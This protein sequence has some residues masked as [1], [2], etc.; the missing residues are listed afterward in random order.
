M[1]R[2]PRVP[3]KAILGIIGILI[4]VIMAFNMVTYV[5]AGERVV[6]QTIGGD[7]SV[8]E[9]PGYKWQGLA[10]VTSY[11]KATQ[12]DFDMTTERQDDAKEYEDTSRCL[13]IRFND[14]GRARI[15]GTLRVEVPGGKQLIK[16]HEQF[17]SMDSIMTGL[18]APA[19]AKATYQTG[20]LMSSRESAAEKRGDLQDYIV[21]QARKGFYKK[22][23]R[24][25]KID[26]PS[27]PMVRDKETGDMRVA[28]KLVKISEPIV[29]KDGTPVIQEI[30]ALAEFGISFYNFAIKRIAYSKSVQD[31]IEKQRE[32]EVAIQTAIAQAKKAEQD[33]KTAKANEEAKVAE[34]RAEMQVEKIEAVTKAEKERD[35]A[36]LNLEKERL[37]AEAIIAKGKAE[38][39]ARRL[40]MVADGAL[41]QKLEALVKIN[42]NYAVALSKAQ[43]GALVPTLIM[44]DTGGGKGGANDLVQ[45]LTAQTARQLSVDVKP[46]K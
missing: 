41:N 28:K 18:V 40:K 24:E 34:K 19:I 11:P 10:K 4:V 8:F 35:V 45:L 3:W 21:E 33:A 27:V 9:T 6:K 15:C 32:R 37:N 30:S 43:P 26:D 5:D 13:P 29:G 1:A 22:E 25:V 44:G 42:E 23:T 36:E 16:L 7:L 38:A 39:E 2:T 20:P 46:K 14:Q 31:Q 17:G 12:Y